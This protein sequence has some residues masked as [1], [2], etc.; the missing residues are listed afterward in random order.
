MKTSRQQIPPPKMTPPDPQGANAFDQ[1]EAQR[2]QA[3]EPTSAQP[4]P[5]TNGIP[6]PPSP[7]PPPPAPVVKLTPPLPP[8]VKVTASGIEL[9]N[10]TIRLPNAI[11]VGGIQVDEIKPAF[12]LIV[13]GAIV[14]AE[15]NL[16]LPMAGGTVIRS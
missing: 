9:T 15:K 4:V 11:F 14:I 3:I 16:V 13:H 1:A 5:G 8:S 2:R 6:S 12:A 7:P 10:P